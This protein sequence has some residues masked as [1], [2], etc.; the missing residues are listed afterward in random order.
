MTRFISYAQNFEDVMLLRALKDVPSGFY[1]D[2]GAHHPVIDSVSKAFY[3]RGWRGIHVEPTAE[4]ADILRRERPDEIVIQAAVSDNRNVITFF[5]MYGLSTGNADI[6]ERHR[7]QGIESVRVVVPCLTLDDVIAQAGE[8]EIHWLKIDVEGMEHQVLSGWQCSRLPWIVVVESTVPNSSEENWEQWEPLLA[9][10]GYQFA[11]FDGLNRFYVSPEHLSIK[12]VFRASPNVFDNFAL[13]GDS[14]APFCTYLIDKHRDREQ[15]LLRNADSLTADIASLQTEISLQIQTQEDLTRQN[16]DRARALDVQVAE[17]A[18]ESRLEKQALSETLARTERELRAEL[19]AV[20]SEESRLVQESAE[21][22]RSLSAQLTAAKEEGHQG[23]QVL[24][25]ELLTMEQ[26]H[27]QAL[28]K[29]QGERDERER[30]LVARLVETKEEINREKDALFHQLLAQKQAHLDSREQAHRELA[31]KTALMAAAHSAR[32]R[33]LHDQMR[34]TAAEHERLS[35]HWAERERTMRAELA[36]REQ[37]HLDSREQ[38]HRELADK[39]ALMTAAHSARE[40]DLHDQMRLTA[41][42]HERLSL[43]WAERERAMRAELAAREHA[44]AVTLRALHSEIDERIERLTQAHHLCEFELLNR[45]QALSERSVRAAEH[46]DEWQRHVLRSC[47]SL[48]EA[49]QSLADKVADL[50]RG[51]QAIAQDKAALS[52]DLEQL[53]A[54]TAEIN[55]MKATASWRFTAPLRALAELLGQSNTTPMTTKDV[56]SSTDGKSVAI[57]VKSDAEAL[58]A[59]AEHALSEANQSVVTPQQEPQENYS[60]QTREFGHPMKTI[61]HIDQLLEMDGAEFLKATYKALLNRP[62]D[63]GGMAYYMGRLRAGHGKAKVIAQIAQ[64]KEAN[65]IQPKIPGLEE[66]VATQARAKHWF[67]GWFSKQSSVLAQVYRLEYML[68]QMEH[69]TE[70]RLI[71]IERNVEVIVDRLRD[72]QL[73]AHVEPETMHQLHEESVRT[74]ARSNIVDGLTLPIEGTPT[75]IIAALEAQIAE[76]LEATSFNR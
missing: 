44:H 60:D 31:D 41:A 55:R 23:K 43:H 40:R 1:I 76:S 34:L 47:D 22:E 7:A 39:T 26:T 70:A 64:S 45:V 38:A 42:E 36:A 29:L 5:E 46:Q 30:I 10:K 67:R 72:L 49:N 21:R 51:I 58:S 35:L 73:G 20:R 17:L 48:N 6:A 54:V 14:S 12:A 61:K 9:E 28:E 11:Y 32:E 53:D 68:G 66:L 3:D 8:R 18:N 52:K 37:A 50:E 63:S 69:R 19:V 13:H 2:V 25:R 27:H 62:T 56:P 33:D 74:Q 16:E 24:L 4:H 71:S 15:E 75:E 57:A 65:F 59:R